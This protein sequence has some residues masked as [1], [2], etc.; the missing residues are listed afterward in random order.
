MQFFWS[1]CNR[2]CLK[3]HSEFQRVTRWQ[4]GPHT[5]CSITLWQCSFSF[6]FSQRF[7]FLSFCSWETL[8]VI[9]LLRNW[10]LSLGNI[11]SLIIYDLITPFFFPQ[12]CLGLPSTT[13]LRSLW[14][15]QLFWRASCWPGA[16]SSAID[17][18]FRS[19]WVSALLHQTL[20][21]LCTGNVLWWEVVLGDRKY[22]LNN[23]ICN[24]VLI[25]NCS[26]SI[27][28]VALT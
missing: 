3:W 17:C 5:A 26:A 15:P 8:M 24:P 27:L 23:L 7:Q 21:E 19:L 18:S 1:D 12:T 20:T 16:A 22:W 25:D 28:T 14:D 9:T 2:L 13:S 10:K 4:E 11:S 6:V